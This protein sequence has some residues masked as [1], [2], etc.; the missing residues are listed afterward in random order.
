MKR[1]LRVA[2]AALLL[3][4]VT[5]P[6]IAWEFELKGQHE[7]RMRYWARTGSNDLF[8]LAPAQENSGVSVGFSGPNLWGVTPTW[9]PD[10]FGV[11]RANPLFGN[12]ASFPWSGTPAPTSYGWGNAAVGPT[13]YDRSTALPPST[14][15]VQG[16]SEAALRL[17]NGSAQQTGGTRIVRGGF[18]RWESD[19]LYCDTRLVFEPTIRIN[20]AIRVH[21][22]YNVGGI[23][24]KF[25]MTNGGQGLPPFERYI[26]QSA[27]S[28]SSE[29]TI[30]I[31]S[32]EQVRATVQVP[33]GILSYGLKDFP[34]GEG[35]FTSFRTRGSA[36]VMVIPYGPFRIIPA[37]WEGLS[38]INGNGTFNYRPDGGDKATWFGGLLFTYDSG[39]F[40][41]GGGAMAQQL[42]RN[43]GSYTTLFDAGGGAAPFWLA[44]SNGSDRNLFISA[45]FFKYFNGRF[46]ANAGYEW[47]RTD[48]YNIGAA[49]AFYEGYHLL[50]E[51]GVMAGPAKVSLMWAQ[52]SGPVLNNGNPTKRYDTWGIDY[53]ALDPYQ[54]LM[55]GVYGGGNQSFSGVFIPDDGKGNMSDAYA[56]GARVDYSVASNLNVWGTYL[57]AHRLE[58]YGT[59]LGHYNSLGLSATA[60]ERA[61]F[62]T[63][64][65]WVG[66]AGAGTG[67]APNGFLGWELNIGAD[68]KLLEGLTYRAR[69]AYWSPG[70]WFNFA[71]QA[72]MPGQVGYTQGGASFNGYLG[73]RDAIHAFEGNLIIDF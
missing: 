6:A 47:I 29:D 11:I 52:S 14:A 45:W 64:V 18:S 55:F 17:G 2:L 33:W 20:Q 3:V 7:Y 62:L 60:A 15:G 13:T 40:S 28:N 1:C 67:F 30:G 8:G 73:T 25:Y 22:L 54:Y 69:Y 39:D 23:R 5:V 61:F 50:A 34:F 59:R 58:A 71:Y 12:A 16:L 42:H 63:N 35:L 4:A 9:Q 70:D 51:A 68:W 21:G 56:F 43:R 26:G 57:W 48:Q 49:P 37:F 31:G 36:F 27:I 32:W 46:F 44:S 19:A 66:G 72:V 38:G 41:F 65:G 10:A 53:Q 24:N